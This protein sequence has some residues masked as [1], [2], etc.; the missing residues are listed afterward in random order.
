MYKSI[1]TLLLCYFLVNCIFLLLCQHLV[2]NVSPVWS[3]LIYKMQQKR[4]IKLILQII[5]VH[6][7]DTLDELKLELQIIEIFL[8]P[9]NFKHV[10]NCLKNEPFFKWN[11]S[12]IWAKFRIFFALQL[13][14]SIILSNCKKIFQ[15]IKS[16]RQNV[17]QNKCVTILLAQTTLC[18]FKKNSNKFY[19]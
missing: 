11:F 2:E 16:Q 7:Y 3:K 1:I 13:W 5:A 19:E 12:T 18:K 4:R 15:N 14:R 17:F 8:P 10:Q 6:L 9:K